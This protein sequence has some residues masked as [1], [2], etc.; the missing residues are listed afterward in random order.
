[1]K[2]DG[3]IVECV[4]CFIL[5]VILRFDYVRIIYLEVIYIFFMEENLSKFKVKGRIILEEC[6]VIGV[7]SYSN[8]KYSLIII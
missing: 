7:Y 2:R 8:I 4:F 5:Y 6:E 3:W 1:M